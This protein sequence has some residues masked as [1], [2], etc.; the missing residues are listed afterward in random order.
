MS[1]TKCL[2]PFIDNGGQRSFIERR[3]KSNMLH[4]WDRRSITDRRK[5]IDRREVL[6]QKRPGGLERRVVFL[7]RYL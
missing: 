5:N 4:M 6:N 3:K 7:K 1:A 2:V